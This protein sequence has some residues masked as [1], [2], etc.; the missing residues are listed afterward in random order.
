MAEVLSEQR[1]CCSVL[2]W[3]LLARKCGVTHVSLEKCGVTHV[4]LEKCG[5]THVSLE[6]SVRF[7]LWDNSNFA[8]RLFPER[9]ITRL[10]QRIKWYTQNC[11][12]SSKIFQFDVHM[13]V[14]HEKFL[15]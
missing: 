3:S 5:V 1:Q 13:T 11:S 10:L 15:Q 4:S 9:K 8:V 2:H 6:N 12:V 7:H 14:H